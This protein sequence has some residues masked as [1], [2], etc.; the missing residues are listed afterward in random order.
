M[1]GIVADVMKA[2]Y[3]ELKEKRDDI[4]QVVKK[5]EENF[6]FVI[7][8][9]LPKV[10]DA[11]RDIGKYKD[12]LKLAEAA[13]NFYDTY[14]M[15]YE[16]LEEMA[17]KFKLKID[18]KIFDG[19][20]E[21]QRQK[22]RSKTKIKGEI[23]SETFAK[24]VEAL[25]LKTEF[26]GYENSH[27]EAKVLAVLENGEVILDKTPFYGESGGQVGDWGKIETKSGAMEVEDAKKIGDTIV[28]IGKMLRGNISKGEVAKVSI[29]EETRKKVMANHTATH[30]LQA[31][32]RKVLGEHVR[33]TGSLVD[34]AHLRFD[35]THMKKLEPREVARVEELVNDWIKKSMPVK[36]EIK[37]L[38]DAKSSGAIALFGEKYDKLVRIVSAGDVSKELCGGTH[39]DNTK[40]V[41]IFKITSESGIASGVRRIEAMTGDAA[42]HW[43]AEQKE[44]ESR[45]LKAESEKEL[46]KKSMEARLNEEI[47]SIDSLIARAK[48]FGSS[49][50]VS[51]NMDGLNIE[52]L[53]ILSDRIRQKEKSAIIILSTKSEGKVSFMIY[54]TEDLVKKNIKAGDLAKS[55]AGLVDGS[56][57]GK[58]AF[59]QGGG[60]S[61]SKLEDALKKVREIVKERLI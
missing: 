5:E 51:A 45:K 18:K 4:A 39:V 47:A 13:F 50:V 21:K 19:L 26:L 20:L 30:L 61:P 29:D 55:L 46:E 34:E 11:F 60:K 17:E 31:A 38:E 42:K 32:L 28:H 1:V 27:G 56:G 49:K 53:R 2:Q 15:P 10:E 12:S 37:S 3:P 36:K 14:G 48:S 54:V 58:D 35:F 16:M 33:Q 40:D 57:G 41:Q 9:Q 59:G 23:F 44:A 43:L 22:S 7:E 52:N 8:A 25:G 24:K 6:L